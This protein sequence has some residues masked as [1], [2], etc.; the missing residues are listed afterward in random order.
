MD[1]IDGFHRAFREEGLE[2]SSDLVAEGDLSTRFGRQSAIE[3]MR[4]PKPPTAFVC[5]NE[6]TTLGVLSALGSLGRRVG[7][8]VDVIAYDDIN[9]SAYFTPPITTFYQP[10]EVLGRALGQFLLQRMAGEGPQALRQVFRP[11]MIERQPDGMAVRP[12]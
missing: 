5:V 3:L 4:L 8:D 12:A 11:T 2:P 6:S 10:I 7:H 1:R 9:V